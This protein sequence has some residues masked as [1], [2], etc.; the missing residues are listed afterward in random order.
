MRAA[1]FSL[2]AP[3][4]EGLY[5]S[6]AR[7]K[8]ESPCRCVCICIRMHACMNAHLN[9]NLIPMVLLFFGRIGGNTPL[10]IRALACAFAMWALVCARGRSR[11]RLREHIPKQRR[12]LYAGIPSCVCP[13]SGSCAC[14]RLHPMHPHALSVTVNSLV[15]PPPPISNPQ[16]SDL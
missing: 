7:R 16:S 12:C 1:P 8:S 4:G 9:L 2:F 3:G 13:G 15:V 6:L 14:Q 5:R 10:P 11:S